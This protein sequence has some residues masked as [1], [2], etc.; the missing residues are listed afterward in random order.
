MTKRLTVLLLAI[1]LV[2]GCNNSKRSSSGSTQLQPAQAS[3]DSPSLKLNGKW[4]L[5]YISGPR[6]AFDGL[7]PKQ[8]P[9]LEFNLPAADASGYSSCNSFSC[10][11]AIT[12]NKI[13]FGDARA[14]MMACEGGG[15]Q[16]FF[17]TLRQVNTYSITSD[18]TLTLIMGDIAMMR[19]VKK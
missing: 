8:K 9:T 5:N 1:M 6:I 19:F 16:V 4:E 7:Y 18:T 13:S 3:A 12:G 2:A 14:T 17:K 11:V 10:K 15:E